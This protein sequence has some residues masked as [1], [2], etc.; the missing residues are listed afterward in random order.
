[1]ERCVTYLH[2]SGDFPVGRKI[3]GEKKKIKKNLDFF[4]HFKIIQIL[5]EK[6]KNDVNTF[7]N[8]FYQ[9]IQAKFIHNFFFLNHI[10]EIYLS[11]SF[12]ICL[13]LY[14]TDRVAAIL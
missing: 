6:F 2:S 3:K 4:G 5:N 8:T 9:N 13:K 7:K 11:F 14:E 10:V 12:I 1:M